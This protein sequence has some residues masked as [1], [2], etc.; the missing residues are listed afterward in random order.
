M[1]ENELLD[2]LAAADEMGDE[3]LAQAIVGKIKALRSGPA[4]GASHVGP[5]TQ[6]MSA[7]GGTPTA[8]PPKMGAGQALLRR[9]AQGVLGGYGDELGGAVHAA[10]GSGGT[11]KDRYL[12]A[13][14]SEQAKDD[15]AKAADTKGLGFVA[16]AAGAFANP[17]SRAKGVLGAIGAGALY[18]H[19][20]SRAEDLKGQALDTGIGAGFGAAGQTVGKGVGAG[21]G[22]ASQ[23]LRA[24]GV[25]TG[26]RHLRARGGDISARKPPNPEAIIAAYEAG[27]FRPGTTVHFAAERLK[28]VRQQLGKNVGNLEDALAQAGIEGPE[29]AALAKEFADE[30]AH[31]KPNTSAGDPRMSQMKAEADDLLSEIPKP[32]PP[33][34]PSNLV[35]PNGQP[36]PP[37]PAPPP[38]SSKLTL[39]EILNKKRSAQWEAEGEFNKLTGQRS[40]RGEG[41]LKAAGM[42]K[43]A[44]EHEIN[45]QGP[46]KAPDLYKEWAPANK[47]FSH[48]AEAEGIAEEG[49]ARAKGRNWLFNMPAMLGG[50]G[51][52]ASG[53]GVPAAVVGASAIQM[54]RSRAGSAGTSALL[55]GSKLMSKATPALNSDMTKQS[56]LAALL[57]G[58]P[59]DSNQ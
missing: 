5:L 22:W 11:M 23:K 48:I 40:P 24:G 50:V 58:V 51:G 52:A 37:P 9:G 55:G 39:S 31:L 46:T 26:F 38:V 21:V 6:S 34:P 8:A 2:D 25:A 17:I 47:R 12:T 1:D 10:L 32:P 41:K 19:G 43:T 36:L 35:G 56:L 30:A 3:E 54:L 42:Y 53:G 45:S 14:N 27:A 20:N 57:A 33:P 4:L 28:A 13:R 15:E 7:H 44:S 59:D 49:S 18:G 16:E 29:R